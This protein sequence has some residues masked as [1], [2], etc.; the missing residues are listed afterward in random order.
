[1]PILAENIDKYLAQLDIE[2]I[3]KLCQ[4]LYDH[5]CLTSFVYRKS[6]KDGTEINIS[7]Q[8]EWV[9]HFY[10]DKELIK[11]STFDKH[12]DHYKSGFV[13]WSQL[14][15]RQLI[16]EHARQ[17]NIDHGITIIHKVADGVEL[18]Y[19]GTKNECPDVVGKHINN[20]DLLER[21]ILYFKEQ[22]CEIINKANKNRIVIPKK[23][24]MV[25]AHARDLKTVKPEISRDDFLKATELHQF[26]FTRKCEG[27]T[28]SSTEIKIIEHLVKGM[29]SE[30]IGKA[31]FRSTRTV[32][33]YIGQLREK[34]NVKTK[35]QL[36]QKLTSS[37]FVAYLPHR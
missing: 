26:H 8:P 24:E 17:F 19:F 21:F 2:Q 5:F 11:E 16:L 35:S 33:D 37:E 31:I 9:K 3:K 20:I 1:M 6:Y 12:P 23:F 18:S 29:T 4:P 7:N 27:L 25:E 32:E 10:T 30:E 13:L 14:K 36:T 34:F 22:A 15:G 28:L